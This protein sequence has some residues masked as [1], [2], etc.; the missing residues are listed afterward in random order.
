MDFFSIQK[1]IIHPNNGILQKIWIFFIITSSHFRF[2]QTLK[3]MPNFLW[4]G[5][6]Y[7]LEYV[8]VNTKASGN[9]HCQLCGCLYFSGR[10]TWMDYYSVNTFGRLCQEINSLQFVLWETP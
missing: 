9:V 4:N 6:A 1:I 3:S 5:N 7:I 8:G 2:Q 10:K